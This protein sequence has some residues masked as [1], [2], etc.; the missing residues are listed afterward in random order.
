MTAAWKRWVVGV[1]VAV[2]VVG[3][4]HF[5][6][7]LNSAKMARNI[8]SSLNAF[9]CLAIIIK[10]TC[11]MLLNLEMEEEI[12]PPMLVANIAKSLR[13]A[14]EYDQ[15]QSELIRFVLLSTSERKT[16][17]SLKP[18][19]QYFTLG[20]DS[21][22]IYLA[23][24]IDREKVCETEIDRC[25]LHL[26]V[27]IFPIPRFL[28]VIN[29]YI[30]ILDVNDNPPKF[31]AISPYVMEIPEDAPTGSGFVLPAA[32]DPDSQMNGIK[33]YEIRDPHS[34]QL[35]FD[36]QN[37]N[38]NSSAYFVPRLMLTRPLDRETKEL[39]EF[40]VDVY[41]GGSPALK[42]T[43]LLRIFVLDAN[44]NP[45]LFHENFKHIRILENVTVGSV[46]AVVTATDG[47]VGQNGR[48]T[49]S[50]DAR[51][52]RSHHFDIEPDTG[53]LFIIRRLDHETQDRFEL[54]VIARD[55]G[56]QVMTSSCEV[57]VEV[58]DVNDNT[59]HITLATTS[60]RLEIM[61]NQPAGE[62]VAFVSV[63]D[64]DQG[65]GGRWSC[66]LIG[67]DAESFLFEPLN[68]DEG[69]Q[70]KLLTSASLDREV[71]DEVGA[72]ITCVDE[73]TPPLIGSKEVKVKVLD[74]NDNDPHF[75]EDVYYFEFQE[76]NEEG[77]E[78]GKLKA[79]D[80]DDGLNGKV[81]YSIGNHSSIAGLDS[82]FELNPENGNLY[83]K[84]SLDREY[85]QDYQ[86][87][88]V[89]KDNGSP[90]RSSTAVVRL[91]LL[92]LDDEIPTFSSSVFTFGTYENQLP[93]VEIGQISAQ[94]RDLSPY[95]GIR[96]A[97]DRFHD[98]FSIGEHSG[99]LSALVSLDREVVQSYVFKVLAWNDYHSSAE[100][101][102]SFTSVT[103]V[104]ADRNDNT[105][106]IHFP[107]A[108]RN[109][110]VQVSSKTPVGKHVTQIVATDADV[111]SNAN[112]RYV[113]VHS[114]QE[115]PLKSTPLFDVDPWSGYIIVTSDLRSYS[116]HL[117]ELNIIVHDE[118]TPK[119]SAVCKLK[120]IV[121]S[122]MGNNSPSYYPSSSGSFHLESSPSK[123]SP[124]FF[125]I[126][127]NFPVSL[128]VLVSAMVGTLLIFLLVV[129]IFVACYN[130][131]QR[132]KQAK[133]HRPLCRPPDLMYIPKFALKKPQ[134]AQ[135]GPDDP[136][137]NGK[138]KTLPSARFAV[139]DLT[140]HKEKYFLTS[141]K[142]KNKKVIC[143]HDFFY[144][145]NNMSAVSG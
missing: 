99:K 141:K 8:T 78:I 93:G 68:G 23:K 50:L 17:G 72:L 35:P 94:D 128:M 73:G 134:G 41:D 24:R 108:G 90:S 132:A 20:N 71:K 83:A 27:A 2:V 95:N 1:V 65:D 92:D 136:L 122:S 64:P 111:G 129:I 140:F 37:N 22:D 135:A 13:L 3:R 15:Q 119:L 84:L 46:V 60:V 87:S 125:S 123:S 102:T 48:I 40:Q 19:N 120:I 82:L 86:F 133:F 56:N 105:P 58:V 124:S 126:L 76:N 127:I 75:T 91:Q 4:N 121:N 101:P 11:G 80:P 7:F 100:V 36:L 12:N 113:V 137:C 107:Q 66:Q 14:E 16:I 74:V 34:E 117:E 61:E 54:R 59:P 38:N 144:Y 89:A 143:D 53:E 21:S 43:I 118:G 115:E 10:S 70:Y 9:I 142:F 62:F 98:V 39:F 112:L 145:A 30:T 103:V 139:R 29:V 6:Y 42:D 49:Y 79:I 97:I 130:R 67:Q 114:K 18:G 57:I 77:R 81:F 55:G 32:F 63:E 31:A 47:D 28:R 25:V 106:T 104:V 116:D 138:T 88:V 131:R 44:D 26:Q 45:P 33:R 51:A 69:G 110:T 109:D 52:G 5:I 85:Q 96:F